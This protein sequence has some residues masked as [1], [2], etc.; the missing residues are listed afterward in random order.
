MGLCFFFIIFFTVVGMKHA[1]K[2]N[3]TYSKILY[4]RYKIQFC[5]YILS[6][7]LLFRHDHNLNSIRYVQKWARYHS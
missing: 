5:F 4:S 2:K 6:N 3:I 7:I 1:R